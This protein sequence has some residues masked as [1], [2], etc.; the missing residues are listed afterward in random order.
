VS[1]AGLQDWLTAVAKEP[2]T[3]RR[4]YVLAQVHMAAGDMQ[5]RGGNEA[6]SKELWLRGAKLLADQSQGSSP[7]ALAVLGQLQLRLGQSEA[8]HQT[9]LRIARTDFKHPLYL[10][11]MT[12]LGR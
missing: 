5:A 1:A 7:M 6:A 10:D 9:A 4:L 8:A 12:R 3:S 2:L 11:L